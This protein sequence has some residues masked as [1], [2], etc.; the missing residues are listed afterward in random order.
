MGERTS[1]FQDVSSRYQLTFDFAKL[2][3]DSY[4]KGCM[5]N[6]VCSELVNASPAEM[7]NALVAEIY[8]QQEETPMTDEEWEQANLD[9]ESLY[10][11]TL[12]PSDSDEMYAI[13]EQF[14]TQT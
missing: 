11:A 7:F 1:T 4:F 9:A 12:G 8:L 14:Y 13:V 10:E 5:F 6:T 2:D 3:K